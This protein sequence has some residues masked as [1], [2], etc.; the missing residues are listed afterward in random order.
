MQTDITPHYTFILFA[1]FKESIVPG[2]LFFLLH[3]TSQFLINIYILFPFLTTY[4]RLLRGRNAYML[5]SVFK[6]HAA[7]GSVTCRLHPQ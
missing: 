5:N 4:H 3:E 7:K 1:L 2:F 6:L